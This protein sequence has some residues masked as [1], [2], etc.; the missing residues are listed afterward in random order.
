MK[1]VSFAVPGCRTSW[2][3]SSAGAG[4]QDAGYDEAGSMSTDTTGVSPIGTGHEHC[5][6]AEQAWVIAAA[7]ACPTHPLSF[8]PAAGSRMTTNLSSFLRHK[9][10]GKGP[11]TANEEQ[12]LGGFDGGMERY[13]LLP[14]YVKDC[15]LVA[16]RVI[17]TEVALCCCAMLRQVLAAIGI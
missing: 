5:C 16:G 8:I 7:R 4:G 14:Q 17:C 3:K 15:V 9:Y 10:S 13:A 11:A 12:D 2:K 1:L 6:C